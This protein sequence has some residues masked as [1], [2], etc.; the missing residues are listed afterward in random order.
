MA[1]LMQK[2]PVGLVRPST[3]AGL[4]PAMLPKLAPRVVKVAAQGPIKVRRPLRGR[5]VSQ[6]Q[7]RRN[8]NGDQCSSRRAAATPH[9]QLALAWRVC[10]GAARCARHC[11]T[12][13]L[14]HRDLRIP[15]TSA[16]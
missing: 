7:R 12:A 1:S 15:P 16:L 8:N 3:S 4:R 14:G 5:L 2:A 13:H 11:L 10:G 6:Q 9:G